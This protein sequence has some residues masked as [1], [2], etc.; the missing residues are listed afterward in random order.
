MILSRL[1]DYLRERRRASLADLALGLHASPDAV[2]A[3]LATLER[4]G[5]VRRLPPGSSCASRCGKCNPGTI[6]IYE[7]CGS[8]QTDRP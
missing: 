7:W 8:T 1:S 3:M 2:E 4:K 5:R 6:Q